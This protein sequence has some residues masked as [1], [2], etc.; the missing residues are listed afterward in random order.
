[1]KRN[2]SIFVLLLVIVG[3]VAGIGYA[4]KLIINKDNEI[5]ALM[6]ENKDLKA[7]IEEI[8]SKIEIKQEEKIQEE[9]KEEVKK[10]ETKLDVVALDIEKIENKKEDTTIV[11]KVYAGNSVINASLENDK[12][13]II[14]TLNADVARQ[15]YGYLGQ[16]E[17][18]TVAGFS[19][20]ISDIKVI[21]T[22]KTQDSV[23]V[24]L[25]ME[26]G[27]VK[28]IKMSS[29]LS[30]TYTVQ[31]V[32]EMENVV[33][34]SEVVVTDNTT[35]ESKIEVVAIKKDGKAKILSWE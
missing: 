1:M 20:N 8:N 2:I 28:Y 16:S 24:I 12:K 11:E 5:T 30:K 34:I 31:T 21:A 17:N 22:G 9:T 19:S 18:H 25:L 7:R 29:I 33:K 32:S 3:L 14:I 4:G 15:V 23:K 27:T 6:Q 10:E 26:D 35:G 13:S